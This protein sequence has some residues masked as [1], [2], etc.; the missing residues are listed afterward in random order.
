MLFI[1]KFINNRFYSLGITKEPFKRLNKLKKQNNLN[2]MYILDT[3]TYDN[4]LNSLSILQNKYMYDMHNLTKSKLYKERSRSFHNY[5]I[6]IAF[7]NPIKYVEHEF[8]FFLPIN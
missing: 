2:V 4:T 7:K 1:D 6:Y 3:T 5:H 8:E